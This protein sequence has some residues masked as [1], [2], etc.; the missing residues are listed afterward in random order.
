MPSELAGLLDGLRRENG[1]PESYA[2]RVARTARS[3]PPEPRR[4]V[5]GCDESVAR[6]HAGQKRGDGAPYVIH[7]RRVALIATALRHREDLADLL[8]VAL[9]HDVVED[10][11]VSP[12]EIR[13]RYGPRVSRA[14]SL[15]SSP[16]PPGETP[17]EQKRRKE[18][19][20]RKVE[21]EGGLTLTVHMSDILD[22]V[23]SWRRLVP[24]SPAWHKLPRWLRQADDWY[25]PLAERHFPAVAAELR[26]EVDF[27]RSRGITD[28]HGNRS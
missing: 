9:L 10:C 17:G 15:L 2:R 1:T 5:D 21:A 23:V 24:S 3:L 19:K 28:D 25:I 27:E 20:A 14:V 18:N 13:A 8:L 22:N 6:L 4:L 16:G 12:H 26:Q 11:G 7:P